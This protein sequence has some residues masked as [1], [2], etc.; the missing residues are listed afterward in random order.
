MVGYFE[1]AIASY[2]LADHISIGNTGKFAHVLF[3]SF[4]SFEDVSHFFQIAEVTLL[5]SFGRWFRCQLCQSCH[6]GL[7]V[8]TG[9]LQFANAKNQNFKLHFLF[10][11][12]YLPRMP[13]H[14]LKIYSTSSIII[15]SSTDFVVP[16]KSSSL[17]SAASSS[18]S[19]SSSS[20]LAISSPELSSSISQ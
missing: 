6:F 14:R 5:H 15:P 19:S 4:A 3:E 1:D 18:S 20:S 13:I 12:A 17:S 16:Q 11:L 10:I 2:P 7:Y 8:Q 9:D